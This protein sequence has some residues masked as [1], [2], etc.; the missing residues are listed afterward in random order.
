MWEGDIPFRI[1]EFAMAHTT[2]HEQHYALSRCHGDSIAVV[3]A[4][5]IRKC[6]KAALQASL[7]WH[8]LCEIPDLIVFTP[9]HSKKHH[10]TEG[11]YPIGASGAFKLTK[12]GALPVRD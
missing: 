8:R 11:C 10:P 2:H 6:T 1:L 7:T 12:P 4:Q 5:S 9:T 3:M